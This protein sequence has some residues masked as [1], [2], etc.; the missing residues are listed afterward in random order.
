MLVS[1]SVNLFSTSLLVY[2]KTIHS[3]Q[4]VHYISSRPGYIKKGVI[5]TLQVTAVTMR[6]NNDQ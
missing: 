1:R 6:S 5:E 4:Y 3:R 2:R